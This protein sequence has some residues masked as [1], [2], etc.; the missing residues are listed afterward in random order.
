MNNGILEYWVFKGCCPIIILRK[1]NFAI[2]PNFP[3]SQSPFPQYSS[4]LSEA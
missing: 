3:Y 2:T 1:M 4:V